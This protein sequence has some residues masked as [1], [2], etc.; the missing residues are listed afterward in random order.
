MIEELQ[1]LEPFREEVRQW[2]A[3][4]IPKNW[5]TEQLGA[6]H[7]Q[8]ATFH[9]WWGAQLRDAGFWVSA[10]RPPT[11]PQGKSRLRIT[12]TALHTKAQIDALV[13]ALA[14]ITGGHDGHG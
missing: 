9:R 7:H 6:D 12:L 1:A 3:T 13:Q 2:C 8:F 14:E 5:R 10:I 11:V 4:H